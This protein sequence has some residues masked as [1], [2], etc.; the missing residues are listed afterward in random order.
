MVPVNRPNKDGQPSAEGEEGR[1]M[2]KENVNQRHTPLTQG[3]T[4]VSPRL[5]GVRTAARENKEL[6]FTA[7]LH[8][9]TV[10]LLRGSFFALKRRAAPGVDGVTWQDYEEGLEGRLVDLHDR[11]HRGAYRAQPSRKVY[12]PKRDGRQRPLGV[13]AQ[14]D[15]IVQQEAVTILNQI[16]EEDFLGFSYGFRP[17][18]SQYDA[19]DALAFAIQQ[20]PVDADIKGF[21]DNLSKSRLVEFVEQRVADPRILRLIQKWLNAGV[22]EDG[23]WSNTE[24][25][26]P[27]GASERLCGSVRGVPGNRYP[28][29]DPTY[30]ARGMTLPPTRFPRRGLPRPSKQQQTAQS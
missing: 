14:E 24:V 16:Y 5:E 17:G 4:G 12:I 7:L 29:R 9:M 6:R 21:F 1:P 10:D 2:I 23:I 18:R 30:P 19:L 26:T 11:V 20:K 27:Q 13:A 25:G 3:G 28:Y 8:H 15:K 22:M